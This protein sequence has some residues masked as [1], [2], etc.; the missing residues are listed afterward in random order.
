MWCPSI[1]SDDCNGSMPA[2]CATSAQAAATVTSTGMNCRLT[3]TCPIGTS[4]YYYTG[5]NSTATPYPGDFAQCFMPP[6]NNWYLPD[7]TTEITAV[8][9]QTA[10]IPFAI[11]VVPVPP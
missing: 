1:Y 10:P 3:W 11:V 6:N 2:I 7:G 9:C 8:A 4:A 5:M